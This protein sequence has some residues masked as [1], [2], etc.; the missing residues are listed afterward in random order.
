[1]KLALDL[2]GFVP[3]SQWDMRAERHKLL[4]TRDS[5]WFWH[6]ILPFYSFV[7]LKLCAAGDPLNCQI[8]STHHYSTDLFHEHDPTI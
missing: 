4:S 2:F 7:V 6:Q 5:C 8:N 3:H 1:M